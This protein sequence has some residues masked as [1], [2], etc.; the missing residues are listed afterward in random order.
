MDVVEAEVTTI[1]VHGLKGSIVWDTILKICWQKLVWYH[2][3]NMKEWKNEFQLDS[4]T[5]SLFFKRFFHGFWVTK[6][7]QIVTNITLWLTKCHIFNLWVTICHIFILWL[8]IC[9]KQNFQLEVVTKF[10]LWHI[11]SHK[12]NMWLIVS[13]KLKMWHF[14]SH[15]VIIVTFCDIFVSHKQWKNL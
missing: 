3:E 13:H 7:S 9:H 10:C 14:V 6:M 8:T 4:P 15:K 5:F 12:I 2:H 11:V 1:M